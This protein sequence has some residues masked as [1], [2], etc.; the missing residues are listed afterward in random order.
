MYQFLCQ[1]IG[2]FCQQNIIEI[3]Y[4]YLANFD[5]I[6]NKNSIRF[7]YSDIFTQSCTSILIQ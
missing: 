6:V 2:N 5:H 7:L 3:R 4:L 1:L